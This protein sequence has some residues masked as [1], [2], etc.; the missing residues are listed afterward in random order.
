MIART[1]QAMRDAKADGWRSVRRRLYDLPP[2]LRTIVLD[3]YH[4]SSLPRE[5]GP[6][7]EPD[8]RVRELSAKSGRSVLPKRGSDLAGSGRRQFKG[9]KGPLA[10]LG[11]TYREGTAH[12]THTCGRIA[13]CILWTFFA[14]KRSPKW[15]HSA[16][17][18][19]SFVNT[20]R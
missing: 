16:K 15:Y 3:R 4:G 12:I 9:V 17:I 11:G 20:M 10:G 19:L 2:R 5:S 13:H 14:T 1:D 7:P 8:R 18:A 6:L